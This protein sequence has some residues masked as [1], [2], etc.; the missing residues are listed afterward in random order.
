MKGKVDLVFLFDGSMSLSQNEF[1]KIVD[2]MKD[3][4][5]KLS[6]T[7]YQVP[8]HLCRALAAE[9]RCPP[10]QAGGR[11]VVCVHGCTY[12]SGSNKS[13]ESKA[14]QLSVAGFVP[15]FIFPLHFLCRWPPPS[16]SL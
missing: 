12:T 15:V 2:F 16:I 11:P 13:Q 7:S 1:E 5:R 6:N 3:V 8:P 4:M 14:A 9:P 10:G